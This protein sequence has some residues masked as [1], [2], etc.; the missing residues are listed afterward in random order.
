MQ[1]TGEIMFNGNPSSSRLFTL[2]ATLIAFGI[3]VN[4]CNDESS[5]NS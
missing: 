4:A 1:S 3:N 2:L 5:T